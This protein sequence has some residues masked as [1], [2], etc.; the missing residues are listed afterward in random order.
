LYSKLSPT[1]RFDLDFEKIEVSKTDD[2][3]KEADFAGEL[4]LKRCR[5]NTSPAISDTNAVLNLDGIYKTGEGFSQGRAILSAESLKLRGKSVT[6]LKADIQYDPQERRWWTENLRGDCH[7]GRVIGKFELTPSDDQAS[8]YLLQ[9]G[10]YDI[11]LR[12]FLAET[13]GEPQATDGESYYSSGKVNGSLSISGKFG[14]STS[15]IGRCKLIIRDMEIG[16]LSPLAK[17]LHVL[18]LTEP[19]DFAFEQLFVDS[20]VKE[21][22]LFFETFDL[23]GEALAF[24]G[25]GWMDLR[26][27]E[28]D[29]ILTARGRRL[30]EA[31]PSVLQSLAEGLGGAVARMEVTGKA[32]D[33]QVEI[34]TLPLVKESLQI[35][36]IPY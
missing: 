2:G 33:P 32:S 23:S 25:S 17:L 34:K 29:L 4:T 6:G 15:Q 21:G 24:K 16:R 14:D 12:Q 27:K 9:A 22:R 3:K 7:G 36:G 28:V 35:L 11:D 19:K 20:Y 1:G 8:A 10:F 18:S 30:A 31:E 26:S 5:L 13:D